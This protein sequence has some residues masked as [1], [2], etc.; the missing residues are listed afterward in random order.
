[1]SRAAATTAWPLDQ[2]LATSLA[3]QLSKEPGAIHF[4]P[5]PSDDLYLHSD[6]SACGTSASTGVTTLTRDSNAPTAANAK[7]KDSGGLH[8][9]G[10][11]PYSVIG[12]WQLTVP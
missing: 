12:T 10:G 5:S 11:N 8:F 7:C 9:S 3:A 6:G 1:M 2:R 4:A